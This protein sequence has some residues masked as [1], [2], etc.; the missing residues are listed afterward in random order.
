MNSGGG[1]GE[2][3]VRGTG[4]TPQEPTDAIDEH[5]EGQKRKDD[6]GDGAAGVLVPGTASGLAKV[7]CVTGARFPRRLLPR[8]GPPRLAVPPG[9][10]E[11]ELD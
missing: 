2:S 10:S 11:L 9:I 1:E 4:S 8:A 7:D 5:V 3:A 6:D